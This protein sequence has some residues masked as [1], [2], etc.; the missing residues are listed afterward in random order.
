MLTPLEEKSYN[1]W[2]SVAS[3]ETMT[4]HMSQKL[5]S[6][7]LTAP[8]TWRIQCQTMYLRNNSGSGQYVYFH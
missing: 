1:L 8:V 3:R 2:S 6:R 4:M 7:L 5:G